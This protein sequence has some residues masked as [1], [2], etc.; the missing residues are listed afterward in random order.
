MFYA[1]LAEFRA[2]DFAITKS[3][4]YGVRDLHRYYRVVSI[5]YSRYHYEV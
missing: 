2:L 1:L 3:Q 5:L 4:C